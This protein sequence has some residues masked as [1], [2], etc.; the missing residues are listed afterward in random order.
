MET[1]GIDIV[2]RACRRAFLV[3]RP[4]WRWQVYCS[5]AC[6]ELGYASS[7]REAG[8]RY[9][10][11]RSGKRK[12]AK[13]Q[14][15]YRRR[16]R[17]ARRPAQKKV[18]HE[19]TLAD[20]APV[21]PPAKPAEERLEGTRPLVVLTGSGARPIRLQ[22]AFCTSTVDRLLRRPGARS[23]RNIETRRRRHDFP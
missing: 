14:R 21:I 19:G 9:Q 13:R 22:C 15:E 10:R 11:T 7:V 12:H 16:S 4:C 8:R 17:G 18:T 3:C 6:S 2:C 1:V 20:E 5:L 23:I